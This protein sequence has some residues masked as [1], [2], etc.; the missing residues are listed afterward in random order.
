[1]GIT[2]QIALKINFHSSKII[3]LHDVTEGNF[4]AIP[5]DTIELEANIPINPVT[6]KLLTAFAFPVYE[7]LMVFAPSV[8]CEKLLLY[9]DK[10][11]RQARLL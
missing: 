8:L 10:K 9:L 3:D 2:V 6:Y 11:Y 1:M 4:Y 7:G 5:I